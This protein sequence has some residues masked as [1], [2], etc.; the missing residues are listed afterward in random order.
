MIRV[1]VIIAVTGFLV[2][3][4]CLTAAVGIV[5]PDAIAR[6]AWSWRPGYGWNFGRDYDGWGAHF[7]PT[8]D[9]DDGGPQTT[10]WIAWSGG[11][12]IDIDLPANVQYTQADGPAKLVVTGPRQAVADVMVD[13]GHIR[14]DHDRQHEADL[15]IVISAP[16]VTHFAMS[17]SG[18]LA[19]ANYRQSQL[20]LDLSGDAEV[21]AAGEA[22][23]IDLGISGSADADLG[24]LK[25]RTAKVDIEGS[26]DAIVAPTEAAKIDISGSGDVTLLTDPAKLESNITGSGN[27]RRG[28]ARSA[29]RSPSPPRPHAKAQRRAD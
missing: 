12:S 2:S 7:H 22:S 21:S 28:E 9:E 19:I 11:D 20:T 3:V 10:R 13:G 24:R 23:A 14:F 8:E 4:I 29:A 15:T 26:G 25:A 16:S 27:V 6:G 5:G 1:L 17:G 18:K